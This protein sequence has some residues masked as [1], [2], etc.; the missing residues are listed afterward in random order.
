M[1]N[2]HIDP[3]NATWQVAHRR[4][5]RRIVVTSQGRRCRRTPKGIRESRKESLLA[6]S[7]GRSAR[8]RA[9]PQ[10]PSPP[11]PPQGVID[12]ANHI[13]NIVFT[14]NR[15]ETAEIDHAARQRRVLVRKTAGDC[16]D[17]RAIDVPGA[18]PIEAGEGGRIC[19]ERGLFRVKAAQ[20][21]CGSRCGEKGKEGEHAR[22]KCR[23]GARF[24]P[25]LARSAGCLCPSWGPFRCGFSS[26]EGVSGWIG[27]I[28]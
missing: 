1:S 21:G 13:R 5:R 3:S 7:Q 27:W 17:R 11:T 25:S 18:V 24:W 19:V 2:G 4:H 20:R 28:V 8:P 9:L 14:P 16:R 26:G 23:R 12:H 10:A 6:T 15:R 22:A